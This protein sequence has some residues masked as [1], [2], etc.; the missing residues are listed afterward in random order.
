M[1]PNI[2]NIHIFFLSIIVN[3]IAIPTAGIAFDATVK[4]VITL[5]GIAAIIES[6]ALAPRNTA[7]NVGT[8]LLKKIKP[9]PMYWSLSILSK[10]PVSAILSAL[11]TREILIVL[12]NIS[13]CWTNNE[14]GIAT[15]TPVASPPPDK[16]PIATPT[17]EPEIT[18]GGT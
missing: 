14:T 18:S 8:A 3:N 4:P 12:H 16:I 6:I 5:A 10:S 7:I 1:N 17:T 15:A 9:P 11:C 13:S 2:K